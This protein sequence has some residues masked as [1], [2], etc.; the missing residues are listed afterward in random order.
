MNVLYLEDETSWPPGVVL[1]LKECHEIFLGWESGINPPHHSIYDA[2]HSHLDELLRASDYCLRGYHCTRLT[3]AEIKTIL[4]EGMSLPNLEML[5][6]RIRT[7]EMG[8]LISS[9]IAQF[10]L[11]KNQSDEKNRANMIWF[12]FFSPHIAGEGGIKR[13]FR[14]W[15]GEAL[16]NSHEDHPVSGYAIAKIGIPCIVEANVPLSSLAKYRTP[17]TKIIRRF[18]IANGWQTMECMDHE[19]YSVRAIPA[20]NIM[21]VIQYP[22]S[23]FISLTGCDEWREPIEETAVME[24]IN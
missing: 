7:I 10:L 11:A 19:G 9:K 8:G 13:F 14:H 2:A 4:T 24:L 12:C 23:D 21:R 18:L 22:E 6:K 5:A 1:F 17:V 3:E 15:G 20:Q 16:Y